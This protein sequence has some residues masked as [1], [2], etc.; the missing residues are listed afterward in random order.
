MHRIA[1]F[2]IKYIQSGRAACLNMLEPY[3][4][5]ALIW[6]KQTVYKFVD[7]NNFR[8]L[9]RN[10]VLQCRWGFQPN[11]IVSFSVCCVRNDFPYRSDESCYPMGQRSSLSRGLTKFCNRYSNKDLRIWLSSIVWVY[12][13][14]HENLFFL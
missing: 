3:S 4:N 13:D 14:Y 9:K 2:W 6:E 11:V 7:E 8:T 10:L 12:W 1:I 5:D